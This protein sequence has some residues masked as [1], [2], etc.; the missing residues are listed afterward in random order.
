ML[1]PVIMI[2][3]GAGILVKGADLLV[4]GGVGIALKSGVSHLVVGL[5]VVAFGTSAPELT[6]SVIAA[7]KGSG[8]ICFGNVVG[9]NVANIALILGVTALIR[10][11]DVNKVLVR[12]EI[13][14]L[15]VISAVIYIIGLLRHSGLIAGLILMALFVWYMVHC[16]KSPAAEV[17]VEDK[18][19]QKSYVFLCTLVVL[20]VGG[21]VLGGYLFVENAR[22]IASMLGISEAVIGLTVVALGTSLPELATSV[23]AAVKGH[24]DI[25][26]GNV[27]G[28]NIFNIL[29]VLGTTSVILPFSIS[30]DRFLSVAGLP[31][32]MGLAIILL[33]FALTRL[34]IS[35]IEGGILSAIYC[36]YT[37]LAVF[38]R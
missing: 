35:R 21:L 4:D 3:I 26:L 7:F 8:D 27:I 36:V 1:I 22:A 2:I 12:W 6:A 14:F 17:E 24:S 29:F 20:G 23:V 28:S 15:I 19:A 5:T 13:P 38:V 34:T 30:P 32:M 10:P 11:I 9:S 33:P 18:A 37:L 31:F 16:F 25:S